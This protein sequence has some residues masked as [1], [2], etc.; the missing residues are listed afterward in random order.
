MRV[1]QIAGK[2]LLITLLLHSPTIAGFAGAFLKG[3]LGARAAG[4]GGAF[5]AAVDDESASFW[6][7]ARLTRS[8]GHHASAS[9]HSMSLG[10]TR[11]SMAISHNLRGGLAFG[12][13]WVHASVNDLKART[14]AG[15]LLG[16]IEDKENAVFVALGIPIDEQLSVGAG[17]KILRHRLDIP[18]T[19][20]STA[21]GRGIDLFVDYAVSE[22][23]GM[24]M[25][26]RSLGSRLQWTVKR[27]SQQSNRSTDNIATSVV[28]GTFHRVLESLQVAVGG[29]FSAIESFASFGAEWRVS[30]LLT[31]RAGIGRLRTSEDFSSPAFGLTLY[32]MHV[33]TVQ[34]HYAYVSDDIGAG[35]RTIVGL[36]ASF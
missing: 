30:P 11:T 7:A 9:L 17:L 3:G 32:P 28:V 31:M 18:Q 10:R 36:G 2:T 27:T 26:V 16:N 23:S 20:A 8:V 21:T 33:D 22:N 6:N 13:A 5:A 24:V 15:D 4:M 14:G 35:A 1:R 29:E 25:G 34:F 19:D 12:L